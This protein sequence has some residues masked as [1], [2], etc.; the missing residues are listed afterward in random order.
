MNIEVYDRN[1]NLLGI[2]DTYES[3]LWNIKYAKYGEFEIVL[4]DNLPIIDYLAYDHYITLPDSDRWMIIEK[5][6]PV[7]DV[8]AGNRIAYSGRSLESILLRRIVWT[9]TVISGKVQQAVKR[10]L[11]DAIINPSIA[12]RKIDNFIFKESSDPYI[13]GLT[14][15]E[16]QFTGDNLYDV[17]THICELYGLGFKITIN[18]NKQFVFELY[19]GKDRTNAQLINPAVEF[20]VNNGNLMRASIVYDKQSYCNVTLIAGEDEGINRKTAIYGDASGLD[21]REL[22]TDARDISTNAGEISLADYN[23][24]LIARGKENLAGYQCI[25]EIDSEIDPNSDGMFKLNED[26]FIGDLI[27]IMDSRNIFSIMRVD[28]ITIND[29]TNTFSIHPIFTKVFDIF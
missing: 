20:S 18:T 8:E 24:Q 9:Q 3:F 13:L 14:M 26:Y 17:I 19:N 25:E 5:Q 2:C 27:N 11:T 22:F 16:M 29:D 7:T 21:R 12:S 10:L 1:F 23:T 4:P 6:V 15:S 28:E